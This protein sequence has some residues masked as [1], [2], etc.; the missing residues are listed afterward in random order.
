MSHELQFTGDDL[1][2]SGAGVAASAHDLTTMVQSLQRELALLGQ[3]WSV[4]DRL[5]TTI[6]DAYLA[7]CDYALSCLATNISAMDDHG[8][9][10]QS[11]ATA[12]SA[13]QADAAGALRSVTEQA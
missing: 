11:L 6:G 12:V 9:L 3:P 1:A 10:I 13:S 2:R 7:I 5:G 4:V 8:K